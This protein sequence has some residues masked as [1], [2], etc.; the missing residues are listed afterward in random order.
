MKYELWYSDGSHTFFPEDNENARQLLEPDAELVT[1]FE[2]DT[3]DDAC[4]QRNQFLG[5]G[6]SQPMEDEE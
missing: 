5:W 1:I 2:A 3:W 6:D 4:A